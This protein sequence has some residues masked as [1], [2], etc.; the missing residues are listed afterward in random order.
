MNLYSCVY[1]RIGSNLILQSK[2]L[3]GRLF[4]YLRELLNPPGYM[5]ERD[6]HAKFSLDATIL[7]IFFSP[8]P[9]GYRGVLA[10]RSTN[11][12]S[13]LAFNIPHHRKTSSPDPFHIRCIHV[14]TK[15]L[16]SHPKIGFRL[17]TSGAHIFAGG[18]HP[19]ISPSIGLVWLKHI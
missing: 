15:L 14:D 11:N 18:R 1:I 17:A 12:A 4:Y 10:G 3:P 7:W 8:D 5:L 9:Q 2:T 13:D 19:I 6:L 16:N